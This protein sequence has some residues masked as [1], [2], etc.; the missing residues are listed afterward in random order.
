M[1]KAGQFCLI[2]LCLFAVYPL[3]AC[4][5]QTPTPDMQE[6]YAGKAFAKPFAKQDAMDGICTHYPWRL[7]M[8]VLEN[9]QD[10]E[11]EVPVESSQQFRKGYQSGYRTWFYSYMD[12]YCSE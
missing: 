1:I 8:M 3:V 7:R 10:H 6:Y 11:A 9:L 2:L 12:S 4:Q 5:T